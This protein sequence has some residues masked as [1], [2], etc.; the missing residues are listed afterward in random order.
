M[1]CGFIYLKTKTEH[2]SP[3]KKPVISKRYHDPIGISIREGGGNG[4]LPRCQYCNEAIPLNRL[5]VINRV[6]RERDGY[7]VKQIHIFHAKLALSND[8]FQQLLTILWSSSDV[9]IIQKRAAW[10][11]S[12]HQ[13][14]G[15]G[16]ETGAT[17]RSSR[18]MFRGQRKIAI[19]HFFAVVQFVLQLCHVFCSCAFCL[20]DM[21]KLCF[22]PTYNFA[23]VQMK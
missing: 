1:C 5:C 7:D 9:E 17:W 20:A 23:D 22:I 10:V 15:K 8:E 16:S 21:V 11:A 12:M 3:S 2:Q 19:V 6:K 4:P 18:E 13:R 14:M